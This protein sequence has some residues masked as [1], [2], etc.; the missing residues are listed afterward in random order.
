LDREKRPAFVSGVP[1]DY[2]SETGQL[3]GNPLYRWDVLKKAATSGGK[4]RIAHNL[5]LFD[6]LRI[7]HF[8]ASRLLGNPRKRENSD[9]RTVGEGSGEGFSEYPQ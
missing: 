7:D 1:P 9:Q 5:E 6:F 3:W 8:E 2:F 4:E